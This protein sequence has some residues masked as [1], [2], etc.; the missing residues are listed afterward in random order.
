[1]KRLFTNLI[2][3]VILSTLLVNAEPKHIA[4]TVK[5]ANGY[6]Y[7]YFTNDP[8]NLR[9]Y[10]LKNGLKIYL[11]QNDDEPRIQTYIPIKA[12]ATYDPANATGLAH[13]LEHMMFKGSDKIATTD[14]NTELRYI[15]EIML[16]YEDH[17][18]EKDLAKKREIYH[19][20]DSVSGI[21]AKYAVANEYDKLNLNIGSKG[22]NAY[23]SN[24][25]TVYINNIPSNELEKWLILEKERFSNLVLRIFH[26]ELE[27][28]Y[29]EFNM[30]QDN[31][32][33]KVF[34]ALYKALFPKHPY[35]TQTV[36]G[37]AEHLKNPSMVK[38]M[39]Y[40]LKYYVPNNMAICL[41]GDL[42]YEKTIQLIDKYFGSFDNKPLNRPDFPKEEPL[43]INEVEVF[44]PE[45]ESV[46]LAY[47]TS[48]SNSKD[49]KYYQ[50]IDMILANSKAG[51]IDLDLVQNQKVL[52]A[53]SYLETM[54]DY[55]SEI[56]YGEPKQ[57][58]S[59]EEVK[60]LLLSMVEKVK[61][62]EFDEWIIQACVN[63]LKKSRISEIE[64]NSSRA[65]LFVQ[66]FTEFSNWADYLNYPDEL[67]KITKDEIIK[68]A[69]E[70]FKN[71][72]VVVYKRKGSDKNVVKV[73]K[74]KITPIIVNRDSNSEFFKT[75]TAI[76]SSNLEPKFIDFK[77][78]FNENQKD[79]GIKLYNIEN[80]TNDL[81]R[82]SFILDMG[83][84]NDKYLNL[85]MNYLPKIGTDKYSPS[86]IQ[87]ELF[88]LGLDFSVNS[89]EERSY[90]TISGL[91][92]NFEKGL[93]FLDHIINNAKA[94]QNIYKEYI[95][96]II[97]EREN[98][99]S[100]K[101]QILWS[102]LFNYG[103]YGKNNPFTD[104]LTKTE[105]ESL[106]PE[107]LTKL[108]KNLFNYKHY[109]F[110]YG[111]RNS[112]NV[113]S[114]LNKHHKT[115]KDLIDYPIAVKYPKQET[116]NN[117]I[118]FVNYDMVQAS[119]ILLAKGQ[120]YS[121]EL[122]TKS[123]LFNEYFGAGL[124]SIVF[125]EI[126]ESK[127]LA[128]SAFASYN[129]ASK[130]DED[131]Y[132]FGFVGTQADKMKVATESMKALLKDMPKSENLFNAAKEATKKKIESERITKDRIFWRFLALKDLGIDYDNRI[133]SYNYAKKVDYNTFNDFFQQS[134]KKENFT[135]LIMAN[136]K[137]IDMD[138]LKSIGNVKELTLEEIFN[139]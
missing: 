101:S 108:I 21:A 114:L 64:N 28:V 111:K 40:W 105:M 41:S 11:S 119:I 6:S 92:E 113:Y 97:Q 60:N 126:R 102:G 72:Y 32:G 128:Y 84:F 47:R 93:E 20:I 24:E 3:L 68:F 26:T 29:E 82:M 55:G 42:N 89:G 78:S 54:I 10:T 116:S 51:L 56:L 19:R 46:Y 58:Q 85:A 76:S 49:K 57:G 8:A 74:P 103:K 45:S 87:K 122:S 75:F 96:G 138:Y 79:N 137:L 133:D 62:G 25:R 13:Y 30:G 37:T 127:A 69:K 31:D 125:Q 112:E 88:K 44:G 123:G 130:K 139:Y 14:W 121:P 17:F 100:D 34:E 86:D 4:K 109:A 131:N 70:N 18:N 36:I 110:Y 33:N 66:S 136:K 107:S 50:I 1:M 52:K 95:K 67:S 134:V 115:K 12:G 132:I 118:Y 43:K 90:I 129:N 15:K 71:N 9:I 63:D 77:K 16:L 98:A 48:G 65:H 39:D 81:F 117:N 106:N 61:A 53:G 124:S 59:L 22:T 135:Y 91:D 7:E 2:L 27:A 35:G 80:K 73:E 99:K 83:D 38:I 120:K 5:D 104:N 23:T 94:D